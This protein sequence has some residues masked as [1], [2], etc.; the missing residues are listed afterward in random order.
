MA[1]NL[2]SKFVK[3]A[4]WAFS[5]RLCNQIAAFVVGIILA[6]LLSPN[7][8]GTIAI[9]SIFTAIAGVL[10]DSG[11]GNA[12]IQKK[13]ASEEDFNSVFY[14]SLGLTAAI[15]GILF[16]C[17]PSVAGFYGREE[18]CPI[19]R[20]I[21]L[22]LFF[23]AIN[24]IQNAELNRKLLFHLSFRISLISTIASAV[25]GISLAYMGFGVWTLVWTTI[26]SGLVGVVTRW[27]IIAWRPRLMFSLSALKPLFSFGWKI[28][29]VGLINTV[30]NNIHGLIIGKIYTPADLS[31]YNRGR[32]FPE[33]IMVNVDGTLGR[34]A[35]PTLA[36]LQ[37]DR[38][39]MREA[40]RRMMVVSTYF[41]FPMMMFFAISSDKIILLLLG[42]KWLSASPYAAIACFTFALWPFHTINLQGIQAVGRSDV[43]LKLELIKKMIALIVLVVFLRQGILLWCAVVAFVSSPL[44]VIINSWP[45]RKL[46]DYTLKMQLKDVFPTM[47]VS[48]V[49]MTPALAL[50]FFPVQPSG[51]IMAMMLLSEGCLVAILYL[52]LSYFFRLRGLKELAILSKPFVASRFPFANRFIKYMEEVK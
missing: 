42:E 26:V 18:L 52:L 25:T 31:F 47:V 15:Y 6:R 17:A 34:V 3:G 10:A 32:S 41:I 33:L 23:Y 39:K 38:V 28:A 1:D 50:N 36:K 29:C 19:L 46:F 8:Y 44:S 16:L 22:T 7:D 51:F 2:K 45:N 27:V 43:F 30:F 37:S 9:L 14:C 11:F 35:Y 48:I 21:S 13:D 20:V 49:A 12:L 24:S 5:E 4:F 40:M